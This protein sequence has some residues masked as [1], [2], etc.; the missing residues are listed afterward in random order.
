MKYEAGKS[1]VLSI[2]VIISIV[3]TWT[4]WTYSPKYDE[5]ENSDYFIDVPISNKKENTSLIKPSKILFHKSNVNY[6]TVDELE[7]NK[8]M[9]EIKKWEFYDLR[10]K[11]L[12]ISKE[13]YIRQLAYSGSVEVEFPDDIPLNLFDS[14]IQID[15]RNLPE[16]SFNRII[17]NIN[18]NQD[19]EGIIH[20]IS[21]NNQ[22]IYE[23]RVKGEYVRSFERNYYHLSSQY[24]KYKAFII[25]DTKSI[26][27][28]EQ[29]TTISRVQYYT[30]TIEP[31]M[32]KNALFTNPNFVKKD[33]FT[34]GDVYTDGSRLL[35]VDPSKKLIRYVNPIGREEISPANVDLIQDSIDFIND[36]SGWTDKY[37]FF[38]WN[39]YEQKTVFRLYFK[40]IPIFNVNGLTE[41]EQVW[42]KNEVTR[43]QRPLLKLELPVDIVEIKLPSGYEVYN[44]LKDNPNLNLDL[45][46]DVSIGYEL[47]EDPTRSKVVILEPIWSYLYDGSWKK[48]E[49]PQQNDLGGNE[50]GLE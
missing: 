32:F 31:E 22:V 25:T 49:F 11:S 14:I 50:S 30:D 37:R 35:R 48:V 44:T 38:S 33:E 12:T 29:P 41:I 20:F 2:L 27:L 36:H 28:P 26:Y 39:K 40:N 24:P 17:F 21:K 3:L 34:Y 43:Y 42:G 23:G 9:K 47:K 45:I 13:D 15:D 19:N 7:I 46:G 18:E 16:V 1:I 8:I 4:L 5:I 6:G 10:N